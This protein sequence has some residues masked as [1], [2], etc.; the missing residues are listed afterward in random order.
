M[1]TCIMPIHSPGN[2]V[3]SARAASASILHQRQRQSLY[4]ARSANQSTRIKSAKRIGAVSDEEM[5]ITMGLSSTSE[6]VQAK[7][8]TNDEEA[9]RYSCIESPT[10]GIIDDD[11]DFDRIE[12]FGVT[13]MSAA[14]PS[15]R[16]ASCILR[17]TPGSDTCQPTTRASTAYPATRRSAPKSSSSG[18][19][20]S[21][22]KGQAESNS[23]DLREQKYRSLDGN[24]ERRPAEVFKAKPRPSSSSR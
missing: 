10:F 15:H 23:D 3:P 22:K 7:N 6:S 17:K 24:E 20:A 18:I 8:T 19:K 14:S 11:E 12:P 1:C 16:P 13:S 4:R 21:G 2:H 9:P 5:N